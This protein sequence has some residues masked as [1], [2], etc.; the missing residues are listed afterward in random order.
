MLCNKAQCIQNELNSLRCIALMI[1]NEDALEGT[2]FLTLVHCVEQGQHKIPG[3]VQ[4]LLTV[5]NQFS[6]N[7]FHPTIFK[8][9]P[10]PQITEE[11]VRE[12]S[13]SLYYLVLLGQWF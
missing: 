3:N 9:I 12:R 1:K 11:G 7:P 5:I 2:V 13:P 8:N 6:A 4:T 10:P